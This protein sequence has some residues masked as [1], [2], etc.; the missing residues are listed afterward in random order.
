[1]DK[2]NEA[3]LNARRLERGYLKGTPSEERW[4]G[5]WTVLCVEPV[6]LNAITRALEEPWV[7]SGGQLRRQVDEDGMQATAPA[8]EAVCHAWA[9]VWDQMVRLRRE[10][11]QPR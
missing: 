10:L 8:L 7:W 11:N 3:L 9:Q 4:L 2:L 1:M 5:V 6:N